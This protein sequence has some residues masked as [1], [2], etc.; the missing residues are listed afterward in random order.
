[1]RSE[2]VEGFD[3]LPGRG[4]ARFHVSPLQTQRAFATVK[5]CNQT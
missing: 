2:A 5:I 4:A 1:M 3:A